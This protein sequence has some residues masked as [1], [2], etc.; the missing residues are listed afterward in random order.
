MEIFY[1][2]IY[3]SASSAQGMFFLATMQVQMTLHSKDVSGAYGSCIS[4]ASP[5]LWKEK[6]AVISLSYDCSIFLFNIPCV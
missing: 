3:F 1:F 2:L 6:R 4:A 5:S